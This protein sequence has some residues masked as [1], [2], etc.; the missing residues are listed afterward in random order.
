[1]V[2]QYKILPEVQYSTVLYF[3][4]CLVDRLW[5]SLCTLVLL[6][7][8]SVPLG[9]D[10]HGMALYWTVSRYWLEGQ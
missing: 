9:F 10:G 3:T 4:V 7:F 6:Y 2:E 1:M 8:T 5:F